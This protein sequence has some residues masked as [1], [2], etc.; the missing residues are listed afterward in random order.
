MKNEELVKELKKIDK[1]QKGIYQVNRDNDVIF[2]SNMEETNFIPSSKNLSN[3]L[4]K[5]RKFRKKQEHHGM[6]YAENPNIDEHN[7]YIS[8]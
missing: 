3:F 4:T 6:I 2:D 1:R 5:L 7:N 8:K